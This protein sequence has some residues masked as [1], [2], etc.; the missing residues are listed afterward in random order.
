MTLLTSLPLAAPSIPRSE[1]SSF[2]M[3]VRAS[4]GAEDV[5]WLFNVLM[6]VSIVAAVGVLLVMVYFIFKYRAR[7]RE[8]SEPVAAV[9]DHNTVLEVV[10]SVI[11]L[12]IVTAL[13]VW[14]FKGYMDLRIAP[15]DAREIHVTGQKWSW[16]FSYPN[17]VVD[18][19]LHVPSGEPVRLILTSSDVIHSLF[20][21]AFRAKMDAVPGRYTE[22]W[23][24][25]D[26]TGEFPILCAE[27]CGTGHSSM[28]TKVIVHPRGRYERWLDEQARK[29][30]SASPAELGSKLYEQ[31][32]C[33]ACHTID[34]SPKIGP[35]LK[36][37]FGREEKLTDGSTV[38]VDEN[39]IRQSILEP[40]AKIVQGF[41]PSM[42]TYQGKLSDRELTAII[43][44]LKTLK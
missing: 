44:Y 9:A 35:T 12:A 11:P 4:K 7:D 1:R 42:P 17:G 29:A 26:R 8:H 43:E 32:G 31:Q 2:W 6:A 25:A 21:P 39:Y 38:T 19:A 23:F 37:A 30:A 20:I 27:Y 5:D 18:G 16:T 15:K 10:W 13:F 36:G 22:L 34:G 24:E 41:A 28:L 33:Q 40:Q 3:P 14:G